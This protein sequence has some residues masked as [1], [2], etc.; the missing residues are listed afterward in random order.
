MLFKQEYIANF[1]YVARVV[2]EL[3]DEDRSNPDGKNLLKC[4]SRVGEYVNNLHIE[5]HYLERKIE[6]LNN[7]NIELKKK[8]L[9]I[10]KSDS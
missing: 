8:I 10:E 5:M 3:Y 6:R 9:E 7:L 1:D 4:T 2:M